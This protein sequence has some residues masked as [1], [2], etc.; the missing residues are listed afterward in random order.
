MSEASEKVKAALIHAP[1]CDSRTVS[2]LP[3]T[4]GRPAA[5][6]ALEEMQKALAEA[7]KT[8]NNI[9]RFPALP[10]PDPVAHSHRAFGD[11]VFRAYSDIQ[12]CAA[13][14]VAAHKEASHE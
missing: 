12:R 14:F 10:F 11:A 3:C 2:K 7:M 8:I 4:C 6:A 5:L 9:R 1:D 13:A